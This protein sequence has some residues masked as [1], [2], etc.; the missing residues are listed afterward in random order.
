MK[1]LVAILLLAF[2]SSCEK[3][4][5]VVQIRALV[6]DAVERAHAHDI[7]GLMEHVTTDYTAQPGGRDEQSVRPI[8]LLALRSYGKFRIKH[9][10]P[11][12]RVDANAGTAEVSLPFLVVR[13]GQQLADDELEQVASSP[14]EWVARVADTIGDPYQLDLTLRKTSDGWKVRRSEISGFK[15]VHDL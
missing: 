8:L 14:S 11:G 10:V 13:E 2:A 7:S 6:D 5:D 4:D 9:P 3:P 15:S 1:I 12:I